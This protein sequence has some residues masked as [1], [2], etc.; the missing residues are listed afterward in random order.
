MDLRDQ[1]ASGLVIGEAPASPEGQDQPE[2]ALEPTTLLCRGCG[3]NSRTLSIPLDIVLTNRECF[4]CK[5]C[6]GRKSMVD[7]LSEEQVAKSTLARQVARERAKVRLGY[8]VCRRMEDRERKFRRRNGFT[9]AERDARVKACG[10][11]CSFCG[12]E[13]A[14]EPG[15]PNSVVL[16]YTD[17]GHSLNKAIPTCRPC[18]CKKVGLLSAV[19]K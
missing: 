14:K 8:V 10:W 7:D 19:R 5:D 4:T 3:V 2:L 11:K 17:E 13:L 6:N 1:N 18:Q 12:C 9:H 16:Y 15:K